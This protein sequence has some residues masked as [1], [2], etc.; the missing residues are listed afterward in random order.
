MPGMLTATA[1]RMLRRCG[2]RRAF[3]TAAAESS[4]FQQLDDLTLEEVAV[5]VHQVTLDNPR[6][7]NAF[8]LGMAESLERVPSLLPADCRALIITGRG[9]KAFCTG[10]DLVESKGHTH[11]RLPKKT[12]RSDD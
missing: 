3:S 7:G 4:S 9:A 10:R 6:R 11:A 5:G 2:P 8:S 1:S 12:S